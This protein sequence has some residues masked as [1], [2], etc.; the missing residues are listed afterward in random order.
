MVTKWEKEPAPTLH[1]AR[2]RHSVLL[3]SVPLG[4]S[5]LGVWV[6]I[7]V[8][9]EVVA[10][11]LELRHDALFVQ[12]STWL[13]H[14]CSVLTWANWVLATFVTWRLSKLQVVL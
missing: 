8:V 9:H 11:A 13:L 10:N 1:L 4:S 12:V 6:A 5:A 7:W 3:G 2:E 14:C